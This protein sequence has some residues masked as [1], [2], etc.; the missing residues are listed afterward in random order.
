MRSTALCDILYK[1]LRN[2]LTYLL[3][4]LQ[5]NVKLTLY[6]F[7]S[8]SP[9]N[10]VPFTWFGFIATQFST[11]SLYFGCTCFLIGRAAQQHSYSKHLSQANMTRCVLFKQTRFQSYS[12]LRYFR[13]GRFPKVNC[14]QLLWQNF[15]WLDAVPVTL[16][17]ASKGKP[18][19]RPMDQ[20]CPDQNGP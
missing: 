12:K 15:Y 14:W 6:N 13:S 3:T 8:S 10:R 20:N 4:Y 2:T 1:C 9:E 18:P 7:S 17:K 19:K 16:P 11:G 5:Q